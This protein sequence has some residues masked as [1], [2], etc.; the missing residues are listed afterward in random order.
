MRFVSQPGSSPEIGYILPYKI[1]GHADVEDYQRLLA[2]VRARRVPT[3]APLPSRFDHTY[4]DRM[5]LSADG[6]LVAASLQVF[7]KGAFQDSVVQVWDV[8]T[9][10]LLKSKAYEGSA[11]VGCEGQS[12]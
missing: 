8:A 4:V 3:L 10:G 1:G 9:K 7:A 2:D 11:W 12:A 5:A 6:K